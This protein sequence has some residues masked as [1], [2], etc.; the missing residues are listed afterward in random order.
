M[1][2]SDLPAFNAALNGTSTI[3]LTAGFILIKLG[4]KEAH[5]ACMITAIGFSAAFLVTYVLHKYLVQGMHTPFGG[6]GALKAVYYF[7]LFTHIILAIAIVPMVLVTFNHALKERF[8]QHR[9]WARVTFPA[10]Y[11][12]SVTGVLIYFSLYKWWPAE[13]A[14]G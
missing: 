9:R 13:V 2:V 7:M 5:R 12:V 1:N 4:H 11:Y 6:A 10:W 3:L 14:V 8:E